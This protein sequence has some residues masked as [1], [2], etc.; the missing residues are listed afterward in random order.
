MAGYVCTGLDELRWAFATALR[1]AIHGRV[2]C[3]LQRLTQLLLVE[4]LAPPL[5]FKSRPHM[6]PIFTLNSRGHI[7]LEVLRDHYGLV[8]VRMKREIQ[9]IHSQL[10][11]ILATKKIDYN[12][13]RAALVPGLD[14]HE[15]IFIFDS[16]ET[17]SGLYGREVLN[18]ILPLLDPRT[19][20]SILVGD[21]LGSDQQLILQILRESII[22]ARSFSLRNA[23]L[24][25]GVYINNL[26]EA[27]LARLHSGLSLH[28]AY[29]GHIPTTYM[30]PAKIYASTTMAG[31]LLKKGKTLIMAHEDDRPNT[32]NINITLYELEHFGYKVASLQSTYFSIFLSYKIER[33]IF[34]G[35]ETDTEI[36]LNAISE[37]VLPL[38]D[39]TVLL[40]E[41][42]HG[43][44][45][46]EKLGKLSQAG[47][48]KSDRAQIEAIIQAKIAGSYIY[49]LKYLAQHDVMTF[50]I[51]L[52]IGRSDGHPTRLIAALEYKPEQKILR[53]ITLH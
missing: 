35:D 22:L 51:M 39:F 12:D 26:S 3:S 37:Q 23:T 18:E 2:L 44:L 5:A 25:Y 20:Q 7:M 24:L 36:A 1:L 19:T 50:N 40:D 11:Q 43:Y 13:L 28:K 30:S 29:L 10:V 17:G 46:N 15:A 9:L 27:A 14:R 8:G 38:Q 42:K 52:E 6:P 33:P 16:C 45:I 53:V 41:A 21:F 32:E 47:L 49:N 48:A 34:D 4:V 31:F